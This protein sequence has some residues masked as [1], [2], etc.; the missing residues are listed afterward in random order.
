[1]DWAAGSRWRRALVISF[2][3][4]SI[5]LISVGRMADQAL[6]SADLPESLI[7]I[8]LL[9]EAN[10]LQGTAA[11]EQRLLA[12]GEPICKLPQPIGKPVVAEEILAVE[13]VVAVSAIAIEAVAS[14]T[15]VSASP[16]AV[17]GGG[18]PV[19]GASGEGQ[20]VGRN[21]GGNTGKSREI[22]P[23][24]ILSRREPS[25][26]EQARRAGIEGTVVLRIAI[27]ENGH[28]GDIS[29]SESSG[30]S[31]LDKAA[32]EAVQLWRFVPAKVRG[33]GKS[34]ACQTT[35]PVVF[36]LKA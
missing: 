14:S 13:P 15:I 25:Y 31:L 16:S 35:M 11:T 20:G 1:M 22:I 5:V 32:V 19:A 33:T 36:R 24:G 8:E 18:E 6:L 29:V 10:S 12:G 30:S 27:L 21:S 28:A 2:I 9:N 4:H 7:E 23:P 26:P 3:L 34:I 17:S